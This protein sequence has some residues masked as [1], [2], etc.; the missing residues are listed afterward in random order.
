MLTAEREEAKTLVE[1]LR[2]YHPR[3]VV[4][5]LAAGFEASA[6]V[7]EQ[8]RAVWAAGELGGEAALAFLLRCARSETPNVRRMAASALGKVAQAV[9]TATLA[10]GEATAQ[11]RLALQLLVND[12][13]PQVAQYALKSLD[14]CA[15]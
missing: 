9:R 8:S 1:S 7:R 3:E 4:V 11:I 5:R 10:H 13:T 15:E 14:Q 12:A 6:E 2:L